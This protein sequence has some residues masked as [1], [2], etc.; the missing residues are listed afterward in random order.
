MGQLRIRFAETSDV[1]DIMEFIDQY[2]K[3][4]H[5]LARD[6]AF[7][8]WQYI[9]YGRLCFVLGIEATGEIKGILGF[10]P[11]DMGERKNITIALWKTIASDQPF[12]G[13]ELLDYLLSQEPHSTIM[14]VGIK[15]STTEKIYKRFGM[16]VKAMQQWYRLAKRDQYHIAQINQEHIPKTDRQP[17]FHLQPVMDVDHFEKYFAFID[18]GLK[19]YPEKSIAYLKDRYFNHP[20]YQYMV[21]AVET[22]DGRISFAVLRIQELAGYNV[23]RFVD[24]IGNL[25]FLSCITF[26]LD[27]LLIKYGAEYIDMYEIGVPETLLTAGGWL[28]VEGSGNIIPNYFSPFERRNIII[29]CSGLP[30]MVMFRGDGDQDRPS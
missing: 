6:K 5:I 17:R 10:I 16:E 13:I 12:L 3:K 19:T 7:F 18:Y 1:A 11:Y 2:W 25:T 20:K 30:G 4:G 14:C 28:Q 15:I 21:Y 23:L 9:H 24:Y 22:D 29:H 8:E 27:K 26:E